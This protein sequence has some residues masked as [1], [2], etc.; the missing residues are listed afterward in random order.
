MKEL[1]KHKGNLEGSTPNFVLVNK[2]ESGQ[3]GSSESGEVQSQGN[4]M[5]FNPKV[6]FPLF[7]GTN[8]RNWVRKYAKYFNLCKIP[9]DQKVNLA[10][11]YLHGKAEVPF[12]SYILGQR[13]VVWDDFIMDLCAR[14]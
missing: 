6:E 12:G 1:E 10:S 13:H 7:D 5:H 11:M 14:F 3:S 9:D 4:I 2:G 8:P